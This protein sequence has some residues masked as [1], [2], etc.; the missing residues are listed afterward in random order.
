MESVS[1]IVDICAAAV[2][3]VGLAITLPALTLASSAAR[4]FMRNRSTTGPSPGSEP[5]EEPLTHVVVQRLLMFIVKGELIGILMIQGSELLGDVATAWLCSSVLELAERRRDPSLKILHEPP[6][7]PL[8]FVFMLFIAPAL[9][10]PAA[11]V[12]GLAAAWTQFLCATFF[13][14]AT[15]PTP[16]GTAL[17]LATAAYALA[18]RVGIFEWRHA[19]VSLG[20]RVAD[21]VS[22]SDAALQMVSVVVFLFIPTRTRWTV[23]PAA[24]VLSPTFRLAVY[25][26]AAWLR[27]AAGRLTF[28]TTLSTAL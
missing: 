25:G 2:V 23:M 4:H 11:G 28:S 18:W 6:W 20:L 26:A 19:V 10:T 21:H 12:H 3:L 22:I 8:D 14:R 7:Q 24:L 15:P 5:T 17:V 13:W 27:V 1:R 9:C 16:A